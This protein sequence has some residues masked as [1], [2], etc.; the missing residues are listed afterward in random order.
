MTDI[1]RIGE[2]FG[3]FDEL[4]ALILS[5]FAYMDGVIDPPSSAHRLTLASL[6]EK[7]KDEIAFAAVEDGKLAGCVF[8][9]PEPGFLYLGKLAI[10]P[11]CQGKGLGR[12]LLAIAEDV[13]RKEGLPSLRLETRIELAGNHATFARWGFSR[14]AENSHP[15]FERVTSIEMQKRLA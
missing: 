4:L 11:E 9:K 6:A 14:T 13:A 7:A 12:R 2:D 1:I 15:G 3:R 5:S 10:A 8:L